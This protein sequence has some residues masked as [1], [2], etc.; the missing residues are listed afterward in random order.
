MLGTEISKDVEAKFGPLCKDSEYLALKDLLDNTI[1]I[2]LDVYA[3]FFRSGDFN[4]YLESCFRVWTIFLRFRRRNYT[5]AP[6]MFLSDIFY[7]ESKD[8]PI[9]ETIKAEHPKF[10]DSTVEIF[11]SFLRRSTQ[12]HTEA[13]QIIKNGRYIS[14]LRLDNGFRENFAHTSTW[15]AYEYSA[16]DIM[17]LTKKNACFLL[18]CFS[19]IYM[20]LF[21]H[22]LPLKFS[23]ETTGNP[24]R[25]KGK[26]K[27][28]DSVSL[29]AMKMPASQLCHLPLGFNTLHKPD[30]LHYCDASNCSVSSPTNMDPINI[31][32]CGHTYHKSCYTTNGSKCLHCLSF[33]QDGVDEHVQ[34]L[35]QSLRRLNK[36][37]AEDEG[38]ENEVPC[39][40]CD[41]SEPV[42][43]EAFALEEAL[44][45]FR[46]Q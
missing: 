44:R 13:K 35:L 46:L 10:S 12:K 18:Q 43:Y 27:I 41:E 30:P 14:R 40:D 23:V 8:H 3:V 22:N 19:E 24:L 33:L 11:H 4:A 32:A 1:P 34:S 17:G 29:A 2:V 25:K 38:P 39:D 36:Q 20:R 9:L 45:K 7:W 28:M 16:R 37:Q 26:G 6:L 5:K 42:E 15:A 31:L 21:H